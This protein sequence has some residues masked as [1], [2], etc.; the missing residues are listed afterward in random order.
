MVRRAPAWLLAALAVAVQVRLFAEHGSFNLAR[1]PSADLRYHSD[2][3]T[4]WRSADALLR[5][6]DIY[7]TGA[8]LP[9]LNPPL[10][11]VVMAPFGLLEVLPSYRL[12]AL[13]TVALVLGCLLVVA[14]EVRLPAVDAGLAVGAVLL[15]APLLATVGL[16][17]VYAFLAVALTGAWLAARRGRDVAAGVGIGI[18]VA[19][20]P[21]L[22]P[23]LLLP[24]LRRETRT[25]LAA[26]GAAAAGTLLGVLVC[27]PAAS[28]TW[29][30]LVLGHP[31]QTFF[32]NASLPATL[33]RL[34]SDSGWGRPVVE[35]PG[36][37]VAGTVLGIAVVVATLLLL[38]RSGPDALWAVTA[39]SLVASPVTWNTYL[40][41]LAP[42]V[43]VVLARSRAAAAP[44]LAAAL[45]GQE[46]PGLWYG[47]D[48]T[49]SALPLS[50]YC[51]VLLAHWAVLLRHARRGPAR[52]GA[53]AEPRVA[54][55]P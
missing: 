14:R 34:T 44:L 27:G 18:A 32:D 43:L 17:Q 26:A 31:V 41:V 33:V 25:A 24:V 2:F 10:L 3:A 6:A 40:V 7:R 38:R 21:S 15:G 23:L 30:R 9:N 13:L 51:A 22:A 42:G 50:L 39:A 11:T 29:V 20:K 37:Q 5:G 54:S 1:I 16:G 53:P 12:F 28:V 19:L 47:D 49:A 52:R 36:G 8:D 55:E 46:W 4:F 45:I 48:G 35:V